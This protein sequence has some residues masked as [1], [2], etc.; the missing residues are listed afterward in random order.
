LEEK[1]EEV[2]EEEVDDNRESLLPANG[3]LEWSD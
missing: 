2:L 1:E 3:E